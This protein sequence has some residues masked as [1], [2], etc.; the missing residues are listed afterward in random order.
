MYQVIELRKVLD[1]GCMNAELE[2]ISH[3]NIQQYH[4]LSGPSFL[5]ISKQP[6]KT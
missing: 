6:M 3:M 5:Y 1:A 4:N 2:C